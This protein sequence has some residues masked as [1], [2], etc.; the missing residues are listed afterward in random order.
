GG[1]G[2]ARPAAQPAGQGT[3]ASRGQGGQRPVQRATGA[4]R[5]EGARDGRGTSGAGNGAAGQGGGRRRGGRGRAQR[6]A[7]GS[8]TVYSTSSPR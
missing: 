5:P 3:T 2:G 1:Q 7:G 8:S 4:G 6:P